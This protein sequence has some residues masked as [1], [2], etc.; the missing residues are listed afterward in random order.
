MQE[1]LPKQMPR[2][3]TW[4]EKFLPAFRKRNAGY[5][6]PQDILAK[7]HRTSERLGKPAQKLLIIPR[8]QTIDPC[9]CLASATGGKLEAQ[10]I[11]TLR[12]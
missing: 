6:D 3:E 1:Q 10:K 9:G 4:V 5:M 7:I 8:L 12:P 2:N 11:R